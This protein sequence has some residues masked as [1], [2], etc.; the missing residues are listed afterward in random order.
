MTGPVSAD[1]PITSPAAYNANTHPATATVSWSE[2]ADNPLALHSVPTRRSSDLSVV[3]ANLLAGAP[4]DAG[5]Y[6][7]KA[8]FAGNTNYNS[9]SNTKT[10]TIDPARSA[11]HTTEP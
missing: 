4:T 1:N 5:T 10:I 9:S 3:V 6:T 7:V 2:S 8:S 11:V